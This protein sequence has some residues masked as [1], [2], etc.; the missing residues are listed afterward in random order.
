M[1]YQP[2]TIPDRTAPIDRRH[3]LAAGAAV[4]ASAT[5]PAEA[6]ARAIEE[7][8]PW[9]MKLSTSSLH[10]RSLPLTEA[11]R[12]IGK[13]G[14]E[15]VDIWSHFEWAGPLCE[16]LEEGLEDMGSDAL[17]ALLQQ[18]KLALLAASCYTA[19][20]K[21]FVPLLGKLGGSIIIRGSRPVQ[22]SG[23]TIT[24]GDLRTQMKQF[25]ESLKPELDLAEQHQCT[26]A[27]E[28][29]SGHSLLNKLDSIK[30]FSELNTNKHLGIALAPYHIQLN[31]ESV[32]QSIRLAGDQLKFFYAWQHADGTKQLPGIGP[33]DMRPWLQ[34]LADIDY[35]GCVNPFMHHEPEPNEMDRALQISRDYLQNIFTELFPQR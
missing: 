17:A 27:I 22:A 34:T 16:H 13:L 18:N 15:G 30:I 12:R 19:P 28:N 7:V 11:C 24:L 9:K 6:L 21:K 8:P 29:H 10:Y 3:F 33:T 1:T 20:V 25:L 35:Q 5:S 31:K 26:L 32:P 23:A 2:A 14:F 4:T